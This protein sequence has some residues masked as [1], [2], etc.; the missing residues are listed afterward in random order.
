MTKKIL[1]V[2]GA[3]GNQGGSVIDTFLSNPHL[4]THYHLRAV[5]RD[6]SRP[7]AKALQSKGAEVVEG[8]VDDAASLPRV[9]QNAHAVFIAT[10][11]IYDEQL[12]QREQR[13]VRAIVDAAVAAGTVRQIIFSSL[14]DA[15]A[16]SGGKY[17]VT[18]FDSKYEMEQLIRALSASHG[19]QSTFFSPA[20]F[21]QNLHGWLRPRPLHREGKSTTTTTFAIH[22]PYFPTTVYPWTDVTA[23]TGKWVAAAVEN[24]SEYDGQVFCAATRVYSMEEI[25]QAVSRATGK[26]VVLESLSEDEYR[27]QHPPAAHDALYAMT[28]FLNEFPYYGPDQEAKMQWAQEQARPFGELSTIEDYLARNP[29]ILD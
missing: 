2:F 10:V 5:T 27:K 9:L 6:A 25:V 28:R 1:V 8:D 19:I 15:T 24:P 3:T 23:D 29:L 16:I 26:T 21:T 13:Q 7:A 22:A 20:V 17:S 4:A 18:A 12:K 14:P 11:T